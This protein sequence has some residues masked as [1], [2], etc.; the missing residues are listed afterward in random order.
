MI[1]SFRLAPESFSPTAIMNLVF[2]ITG[3]ELRSLGEYAI[4]LILNERPALRT[5]FYVS[6]I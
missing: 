2:P 1:V 5:P 6:K 4:D 3:M